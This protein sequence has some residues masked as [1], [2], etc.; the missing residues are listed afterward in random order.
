MPDKRSRSLALKL[1]L[2]YALFFGLT[3]IAGMGIL[4]KLAR[5]HTLG[6]L[7]QEMLQRRQEI[8]LA[9]ERLGLDELAKEFGADSEA[10][11]RQDY[12]IRLL[13]SHGQAK[14]SSDISDWPTIPV[15]LARLAE[16]EPGAWYFDAMPLPGA[17][18]R[19]RLL[20][21]RIDRDSVL[22]IGMSMG[23]SENFLRN[24]GNDA[25]IILASMIT[26]GTLIGWWLARKAM[27]G[28][29]AVT[30]I[31]EGIAAGDFTGRVRAA[32]HGREIDELVGT[33][34]RMADRV[35][36]LM[37]QMREVND[38]IAHDLR[39]PLTR[40]RGQAE[41][42]IV[43]GT[44][45]GEAADLAG[46][47]I[48]DC[49]QLIR[50]INTM[51]DISETEAGVQDMHL[52][53]L[54]PVALVEEVV[55]TFSGVA[56]DR[57]IQ[58]SARLE[59]I[60]PARCDGRRLRRA[61]FNLLDNAL[62]YTQSGGTVEVTLDQDADFMRVAVRDSGNGIPEADLP[63]LFERFYRADQ[64]RHLPGNG[65]GLS[66]VRAI[67]R[68]HG[69]DIEVSSEVGRGSCFTL[70]VPLR[71]GAKGTSAHTA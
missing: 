52:T 40:I 53:S 64:S 43:N 51:L 36:T 30:R 60:G 10:Y 49:D 67:A 56:E 13:D 61:L 50:M 19:A 55:D 23:E 26:I 27:G 35:Q 8:A 9:V 42:G 14:V 69:G 68:A 37:E 45:Q 17:R 20:M 34:N 54:D 59:R 2:F 63:R 4:Y 28:V 44:F 7:D 3:A 31:A 41:S 21:A 58:L 57:G 47:M 71:A 66:L 25:L 29:E 70:K 1:A 11:G 32:G 6:E 62:K 33:F 65:L 46:S 48:E 38:N 18:S 16:L 5:S 15:D 22:Q 12:F 39:G 24:F